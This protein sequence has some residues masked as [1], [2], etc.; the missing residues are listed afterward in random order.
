MVHSIIINSFN[1]SGVYIWNIF[2]VKF[3]WKIWRVNL[4]I[5]IINDMTIKSPHDSWNHRASVRNRGPGFEVICWRLAVP[6]S[7]GFIWL[8]TIKGVELIHLS[9]K[10]WWEEFRAIEDE[11]I[12]LVYNPSTVFAINHLYNAESCNNWLYILFIIVDGRRRTKMMKA[13]TWSGKCCWSSNN[14]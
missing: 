12:S 1:N 11:G 5:T 9:Y 8:F 7:W 2:R 6:L 13:L 4:N 14:L 10:T 3:N